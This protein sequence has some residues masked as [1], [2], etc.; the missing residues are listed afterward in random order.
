METTKAF[1]GLEC[2]DCG[3]VHD[4]D[5][6]GGCPNCN[7]PLDPTYDLS[8]VDVH[9]DVIERPPDPVGMWAFD[10]VLPFPAGTRV[11]AAEGG[12][13]LVDADRLAEELGVAS[14]E[15]K[16]E[17][18]N[19]TGTVLDRGLSLAVTAAAGHAEGSDVEPLALAA[20]GNAAQS[21]A[22]Y[23]GRVDL[24]LYAFVPSRCAFSNKAM[25]NVHGGEMQ[26]V[27]GRYED[28]R[29]A[30]DD[31]LA[32]DYYSLQE[33]TT[34]YRHEGVKT[35][36]LELLADRDWTAPDAVF[37]P[38][39]TG[40]LLVGVVRGFEL[41]ADLDLIERIPDVIAVQP[42]GCAPIAAA[43]EQGLGQPEPW[44]VPDT[45][46]GELEIPDP[47]GGARALGALDRI[48][49]R[50]VTV[51]D[52]EILESAVTINQTTVVEMGP[53]GGAAA[54]GAWELASQLDSDAE[55]VLLNTESGGKTPDVL[56][57]HLMS[58]GI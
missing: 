12:T 52:E 57:S 13:P 34:P 47:E 7:G 54:A 4:A 28:A 37:V 31:Q 20:A 44:D 19:P 22:A 8:A 35:V 6:A 16:D 18:R 58:K 53:G 25:V 2:T 51:E 9:A 39:G 3:A 21:A 17:S 24:R 32:A 30:I 36:A 48:G 15:I 1:S 46:V 55:V 5:T 26:V 45:I 42:S 10:A 11:S 38:T 43:H 49:G 14:V 56:R 27:G 40:E 33:F 23:A 50:A 29:A 41:A